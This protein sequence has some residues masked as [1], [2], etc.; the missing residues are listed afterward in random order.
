MNKILEPQSSALVIA[1]LSNDG[2]LGCI[3][4]LDINQNCDLLELRLDGLLQNL[5]AIAPAIANLPCP[6]LATARHPDEGGENNLSIAQRSELLARFTP[7]S[8]WMDVELR[9]ITE[10]SPVIEEARAQ[11][12]GIVTSFHD[13]EKCP[14]IEVLR[15]KIATALAAHADIVKLAVR[16]ETN[17][18]LFGVAQLIEEFPDAQLSLMGMGPL[19]KLSRLVLA[20]AGS[21][22]NYGYLDKPNAPGQWPSAQLK[23]LISEL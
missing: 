14:Q 1:P 17:A 7:M 19:G 18:E 16:M 11:G 6:I 9:S 2:D 13:F 5:E 23:S 20:K 3:P 10:L 12:V 22:L 4:T 21:V 15:E 8:S